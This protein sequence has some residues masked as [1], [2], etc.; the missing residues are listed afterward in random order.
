MLSVPLG[1]GPSPP[2]EGK[3]VLGIGFPLEGSEGLSVLALAR[4]VLMFVLS[5]VLLLVGLR[6]GISSTR[7]FRILKDG[8]TQCPQEHWLPAWR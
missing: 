7:L 4:V 6:S 1:L 3:E 5:L 8:V 2:F